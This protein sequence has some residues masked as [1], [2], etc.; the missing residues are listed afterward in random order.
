MIDLGFIVI[1]SIVLFSY[2]GLEVHP[3]RLEYTSVTCKK[4]KKTCVALYFEDEYEKLAMEAHFDCQWPDNLIYNR[5]SFL[6]RFCKVWMK[7]NIIFFYHKMM[8]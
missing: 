6:C 7:D 3:T 2:L 8:N 1:F 4:K 5:P